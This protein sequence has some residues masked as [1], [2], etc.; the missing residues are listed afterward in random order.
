MW[1]FLSKISQNW[2][3]KYFKTARICFQISFLNHSLTHLTSLS[4]SI[5]TP[6]CY[7]YTRFWCCILL[8]QRSAKSGS[9]PKCGPPQHSIRPAKGFDWFSK[10]GR[11]YS[12]TNYCTFSWITFYTI[13]LLWITL[14]SRIFS[15]WYGG[16]VYLGVEPVT[17]MLLSRTS[18]RL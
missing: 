7:C 4:S 14:H 3:S 6:W 17:D 13:I 18:G 12:N 2:N 8:D 16:T 9:W 15:L 11:N 1:C 5:M 10:M